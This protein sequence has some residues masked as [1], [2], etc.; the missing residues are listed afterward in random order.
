[1]VCL[2]LLTVCLTQHTVPPSRGPK[3]DNNESEYCDRGQNWATT[4]CFET[5]TALHRE[6]AA[7]LLGRL[8]GQQ[9]H[10]T[11]DQLH[12]CSQ[13]IVY[14]TVAQSWKLLI[15]RLLCQRCNDLCTRCCWCASCQDQQQNLP[16]RTPQKCKQ[17]SCQEGTSLHTSC[18]G[19]S[20]LLH[21]VAE[22]M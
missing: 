1:M 15:R 11:T 14:V 2:Y 21:C 4:C 3:C 17:L 19:L 7:A 20:K 13:V 9:S 10:F 12:A 22:K 6:A 18:V 5:M 16:H 8:Q